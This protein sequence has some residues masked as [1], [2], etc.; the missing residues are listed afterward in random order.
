MRTDSDLADGAV[1]ES[2]KWKNDEIGGEGNSGIDSR[3]Q[4]GDEIIN[5]DPRLGQMAKRA[6]RVAMIQPCERR[7]HL[8]CTCKADR[9]EK[10][11]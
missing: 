4:A 7:P 5:E 2:K 9:T 8:L 1:R 3:L 10:S 11:P 6:D